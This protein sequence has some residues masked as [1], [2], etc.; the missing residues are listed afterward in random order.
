MEKTA[1]RG[2]IRLPNGAAGVFSGEATLVEG[3]VR[4]VGVLQVTHRRAEGEMLSP[5][6]RRFVSSTYEWVEE[7]AVDEIWSTVQITALERASN[8]GLSLMALV[9]PGLIRAKEDASA[10]AL[11][12]AEDVRQQ[13]RVAFK[14][15]GFQETPLQSAK[16]LYL[17]GDGYSEAD[18][19]DNA[20]VPRLLLSSGELARHGWESIALSNRSNFDRLEILEIRMRDAWSGILSL[21]V[22]G[23][24]FRGIS[25][26]KQYWSP[27]GLEDFSGEIP[28]FQGEFPGWSGGKLTKTLRLYRWRGE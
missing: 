25:L 3:G 1:L 26:R 19:C 22:R 12:A 8:I 27:L 5:D 24:A 7:R 23:E 20:G 18:I 17:S 9:E 28:S 10:D 21:E 11:A 16:E 4:L 15:Q 2:A 6:E 13:L 14:E